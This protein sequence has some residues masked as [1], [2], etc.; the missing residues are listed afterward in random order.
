MVIKKQS[1]VALSSMEAEY[2]AVVACSCQVM[3][4]RGILEELGMKQE[5][6]TVIKCDNTSTIKLSKKPS[7]S[8]QMQE[9]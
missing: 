4:I 8:C 3:W 5:S 9:Y 1:I 7:L 6:G 2:M